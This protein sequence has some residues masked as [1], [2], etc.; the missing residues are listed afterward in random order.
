MMPAIAQALAAI[1][2]N[3][4]SKSPSYRVDF[5]IRRLRSNL[6]NYHPSILPSDDVKDVVQKMTPAF[7]RENNKWTFPQKQ[8]FVENLISGCRSEI[9]LYSLAGDVGCCHILDGLQRLTAVAGFIQGDFAVWGGLRFTE[10]ADPLVFT[11]GKMSLRIY[12]FASQDE[13]IDFYIAMNEGITHS[14]ADIERARRVRMQ[15]T[16]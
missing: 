4:F 5:D 9:T 10:I 7:Q 12:D 6:D 14:P 3:P 8:R 13:A 15:Y 16:L 11:N 1:A 2:S